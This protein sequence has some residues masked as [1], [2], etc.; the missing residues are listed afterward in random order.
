MK[1]LIIILLLLFGICNSF[2][3]QGSNNYFGQVLS[4]TNN[5][6]LKENWSFDLVDTRIQ[7]PLLVEDLNRDGKSEIVVQGYIEGWAYLINTDGSYVEG[8]PKYV[9]DGNASPV[10]GNLDDDDDL[11]IIFTTYRN[12]IYAFN[13]KWNPR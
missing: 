9:G 10:S 3:A 6:N 7:A 12:G 11:E 1:H 8:W 2:Y 13:Y 5:T 4:E